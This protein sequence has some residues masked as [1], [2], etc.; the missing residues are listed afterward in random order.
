MK[1]P[2]GLKMLCELHPWFGNCKKLLCSLLNKV[3][4]PFFPN[5]LTILSIFAIFHYVLHNIVSRHQHFEKQDT[6]IEKINETV[7]SFFE[8]RI[9]SFIY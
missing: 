4:P 9:I 7:N 6:L 8:K 5:E 1:P 2:R 3:N